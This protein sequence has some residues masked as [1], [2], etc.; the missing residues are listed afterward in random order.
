M[1][2][3]NVLKAG[4]AYL[5]LRPT[6]KV[7]VATGKDRNGEL[8]RMSPRT[9]KR[10]SGV[11]PPCVNTARNARNPHEQQKDAIDNRGNTF[12]RGVV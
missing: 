11:K 2:C 3:C 9:G 7:I 8:V 5:L 1:R 6:T 4:D 12:L 10:F